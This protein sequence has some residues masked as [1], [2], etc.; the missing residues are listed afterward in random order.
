MIDH[1]LQQQLREKYNPDGSEL[2]EHQLKCKEILDIVDKICR[3]NDI[4]YWLGSGTL[5]GAV[6]HGGFIPWDDD[7]DIEILHEDRKR[8][9]RACESDL[10]EGFV[11]QYHGTDPYHFSQIIK[12]R[13]VE[14]DIRE[15]IEISGTEY[16]KVSGYNGYFIDVFTEEPSTRGLVRLSNMYLGFLL[17][18]QYRLKFGLSLLTLIY[19]AGIVLFSFMRLLSRLNPWA[20]RYFHSYGS[21]FQ[22]SRMKDDILPTTEI[23]FEGSVY[24]APHSPHG[25]LTGMYGEYMDLPEDCF[26]IPRHDKK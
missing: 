19:Y 11:L 23:S 26:R 9:I 2:R 18:A 17:Y 22:S 16:D 12:I 3:D 6:R 20:R 7:V 8:F 5:L 25:Y 24:K 10:P 4:T 21:I 13:S 1:N 15:K 14:G